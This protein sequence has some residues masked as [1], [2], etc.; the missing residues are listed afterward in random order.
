MGSANAAFA[1]YSFVSRNQVRY[2]LYLQALRQ[3]H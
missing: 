3:A 2:R 1:T